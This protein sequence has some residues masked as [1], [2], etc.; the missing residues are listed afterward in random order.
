MNRIVPYMSCVTHF[1]ELFEIVPFL[2]TRR[3]RETIVDTEAVSLLRSATNDEA[4]YQTARDLM[5]LARDRGDHET[6]TLYTRVAIRIAEITGRAIGKGVSPR[7]GQPTRVIE[8]DRTKR[9]C[10]WRASATQLDCERRGG[11]QGNLS[12]TVSRA[13]C[14]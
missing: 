10:R 12:L 9:I 11:D 13:R 2:R 5:R 4:A 14:S 1:R 7:Y 6:A 3:V 8:G